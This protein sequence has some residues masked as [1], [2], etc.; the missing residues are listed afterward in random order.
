MSLLSSISVFWNGCFQSI[1]FIFHFEWLFYKGQ[2]GFGRDHLPELANI[3]S[4]D[5][6]IM[7]LDHKKIANIQFMEPSKVFD[8]PNHEILLYE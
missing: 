6:I 4:V 8:A 7:A 5:R 1:V 3:K 2:Y